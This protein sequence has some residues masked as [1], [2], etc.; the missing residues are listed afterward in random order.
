MHFTVSA[1]LCADQKKTLR[2]PRKCLNL[3]DCKHTTHMQTH[4]YIYVT[5]CRFPSK[6]CQSASLFVIFFCFLSKLIASSVNSF[7]V[8]CF[9]WWLLLL[10]LLLHVFF[11]TY[12]EDSFKASSYFTLLRENI[13]YI[14]IY[15]CMYVCIYLCVCFIGNW[16]SYL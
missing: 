7:F 16:L 8:L 4:T 15:I 6:I 3:F 11:S 9:Y 13:K 2:T 14:Y 1:L 12:F 10:L 5:S